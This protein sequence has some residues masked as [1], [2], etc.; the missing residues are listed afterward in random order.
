[1]QHFIKAKE[2]IEYLLTV[3]HEGGRQELRDY[4]GLCGLLLEELIS[5]WD[6]LR[7]LM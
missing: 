4:V 6:K 7:E 3:Y 1:M 5:Y 2:H